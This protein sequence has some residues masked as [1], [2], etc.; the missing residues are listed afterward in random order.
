MTNWDLLCAVGEAEEELL[1]PILDKKPRRP[2]RALRIALLAA[3]L[4]ALLALAALAAERAGLLERF[5]PA[6]YDLIADYVQREAVAEENGILRLTLCEAVS[7]GSSALVVY[8]VRRL[9]GES[10]AGWEPE[11]ELLPLVSSGFSG[12]IGSSSQG[13]IH[14]EDEGE[15][16]RHYWWRTDGRAGMTEISLRL[17]GLREKE[18]GGRI[19]AGSLLIRARLSPCPV[20]TGRGGGPEQRNFYPGIVLSP[21]S[22]RIEVWPNLAG[23]TPENAP[24]P[25]AV[26]HSKPENT[27]E[28]K[29]RDGS[30][31]DVTA[32]L[33]QRRL[34][35]SSERLSGSFDEPLDLNTV[36]AVRIDGVDYPLREGSLPP[37]RSATLE[38]PYLDSLRE[39]VYGSHEPLHPDLSASA[40]EV[41][42]AL[43]GIWTDGT[44]T[45]LFLLVEASR[46]GWTDN[47]P[48]ETVDRG[49]LLTL[50]AED[51]RGRSL[52][53]GA[54]HY[55][56]PEGILGLVVECEKTAARL[57]IGDGDASLTVPL[58]MKKLAALPQV[59]EQAASP[60]TGDPEAAERYWQAM[61]D[62]HFG[63]L[64]PDDSGYG[65]DN[66]VYSFTV[67]QL[68]LEAGEEGMCFDAL[69]ESRRLDGEMHEWNRTPLSYSSRV[70]EATLL[71]EGGEAPL[72]E[73]GGF[74]LT[75]VGGETADCH[76]FW[77]NGEAVGD[78]R[79]LEGLRLRFTPP[80]GG[81]ITLDLPVTWEEDS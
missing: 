6:N 20:K 48:W 57:I 21:L 45:E 29:L 78:L 28:L 65:G 60:R 58:D 51:K 12:S 62:S 22:L 7:D 56:S 72:G 13:R 30:C 8:S 31:R 39:Y 74:G 73:G 59:E 46:E 25:R 34:N 11:I 81:R 43:D 15:D 3:A 61:W 63:D 50:R 80:E 71:L 2:R 9:D 52:G 70:F 44:T 23:M 77:L 47:A 33:T 37:G 16:V 17:L 4:L 24:E 68:L 55:T 75:G 14:V 1:S 38:G 67:T 32:C 54:M 41:S 27:V 10:M 40:G 36:R 26:Y 76:V 66:G 42:L 79:S 19:D 5:F 49:G 64:E 69:C 18:G 35:A 53:L